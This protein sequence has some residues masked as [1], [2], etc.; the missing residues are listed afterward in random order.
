MF[1]DNDSGHD[2]EPLCASPVVA[3]VVRARGGD[4][5]AWV[6]VMDSI[7]G[8]APVKWG[9]HNGWHATGNGFG[10]PAAGP[11]SNGFGASAS[12]LGGT[13][14]AASSA[15]SCSSKSAGL[16]RPRPWPRWSTATNE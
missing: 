12:G 5:R 2:A 3:L 1:V 4:E 7:G 9:A 13:S 16:R 10:A 11:T 15:A 14:N 6:S 8:T